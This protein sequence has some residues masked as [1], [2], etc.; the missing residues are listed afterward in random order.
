MGH[1]GEEGGPARAGH[2]P[3]P[4]SPNRTRKGGGAPPFLLPLPLPFPLLVGVGKRRVLLLLG[5]GL[6]LQ[7][8]VGLPPLALLEKE[9]G[10]EKEER[11]A[12]PLPCPIR[13]RGEGA[14]G[15]PWPALLLSLM[16]H[17]GPITPRGGS[18]NPAVL[19]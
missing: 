10:R 5:G 17:V 14:R 6:L 18:G 2:A 12:P 19:R 7:P 16:A 1:K 3:L 8:G 13:T 4:P 11:G 9:G 15:L